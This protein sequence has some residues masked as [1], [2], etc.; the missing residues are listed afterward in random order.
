MYGVVSERGVTARGC[1]LLLLLLFNACEHKCNIKHALYGVNSRD[2]ALTSTT[3]AGF[4]AAFA[5]FFVSFFA[6]AGA[7]DFDLAVVC[8]CVWKGE[9]G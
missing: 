5:G 2:A 9:G 6:E 4:S 3:G 8:F 7:G 1:R